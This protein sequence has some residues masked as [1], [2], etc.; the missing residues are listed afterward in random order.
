[1]MPERGSLPL[2]TETGDITGNISGCSSCSVE[3]TAGY[4]IISYYVSAVTKKRGFIKL[5]PVFNDCRQPLYASYAEA[6]KK[7]RLELSRYFVIGI[8]E[9]TRLFFAWNA[10]EGDSR[11][12]MNLSI[13]KLCRQ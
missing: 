6:A 12:N 5:T 1:M 7:Q 10:S 13:V 3:L 9:D 11:I 2:I 8:P 4:Y